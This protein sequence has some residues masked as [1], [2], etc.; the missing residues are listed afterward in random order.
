MPV[1]RPR[2][3]DLFAAG[4][5]AAAVAGFLVSVALILLT[6]PQGW[7]A[8]ILPFSLWA[9]AWAVIVATLPAMLLGGILTAFRAERRAA[10]AGTGLLAGLIVHVVMWGLPASWN[11]ALFAPEGILLALIDGAIG[12][13]AALT[14]RRT[15][16]RLAERRAS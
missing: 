15:M 3:L 14:F 11:S 16:R 13:L 4:F 9:A 12:A 1:E 10:W 6:H 2:L 8:F 7:P 5:A